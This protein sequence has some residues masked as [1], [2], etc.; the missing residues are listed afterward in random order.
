VTERKFRAFLSGTLGY[1]ALKHGH[2]RDA[3]EYLL[4][5]IYYYPFDRTRLVYALLAVG[6]GY[7]YKP[8]RWLARSFRDGGG[9]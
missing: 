3:R 5:S 2:Y 6:G 8:A 7:S 1:N 9:A 4:E